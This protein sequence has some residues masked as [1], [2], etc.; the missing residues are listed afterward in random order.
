MTGKKSLWQSIQQKYGLEKHDY[1]TLFSWAFGDFVFSWDYDFLADGSKARRAGFHEYVN[2]E[3]MFYSL[4]ESFRK[5]QV[6]P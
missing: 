4:F 6:I 5:D 1:D 2:T 3:E